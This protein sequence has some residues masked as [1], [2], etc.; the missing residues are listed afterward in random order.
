MDDIT[1][2]EEIS[3]ILVSSKDIEDKV[4]EIGKKITRDYKDDDAPLILLGILKGSVMFLTDLARKIDL[5]ITFDFMS[6]SSY[7][8][9]TTSSGDVRILKDLD[10]NIEGKNVIIVEDIVD[11]GYTM[12]YVIKTLEARK[13]KS[14]KVASLL[15]KEQ[16]R[17]VNVKV[18][19]LGFEIPDEF[20]VGYGI[21]YAEKYRNLPFIGVVKREAYE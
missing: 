6:V 19:Y 12:N 7:G 1:K 20:V 8:L 5:P 14:I 18:D 4:E 15:N 2:L 10:Q 13:A 9:S 3:Y 21:D 16:R 11:T 17:K